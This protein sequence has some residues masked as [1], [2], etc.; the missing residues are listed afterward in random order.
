MYNTKNIINIVCVCCVRSHALF[1]VTP[2]TAACQ[3]LQENLWNFSRQVY[4]SRL[5]FPASG[6]IP[7]PVI[8]SLSLVSPPLAGGFYAT[9]PPGKS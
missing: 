9:G 3:A 8:E 7:G 2:W 1:F 6:D 5:T 4:W